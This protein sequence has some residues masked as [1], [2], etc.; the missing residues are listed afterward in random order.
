MDLRFKLYSGHR[1]VGPGPAGAAG[2]GGGGGVAGGGGHGAAQHRGRGDRGAAGGD[3]GGAAAGAGKHV[4]GQAGEDTVYCTVLYRTV[5]YCT[6]LYTEQSTRA[7]GR[8]SSD[9]PI[10]TGNKDY[11]TSYHQEGKS[12]YQP[13]TNTVVSI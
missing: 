10:L 5:L 6:V 2:A 13:G 11:G 1:P 9:L 12:R 7:G 8:K 4:P 3:H